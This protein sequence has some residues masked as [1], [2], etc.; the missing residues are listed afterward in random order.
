MSITDNLPL[1]YK[2]PDEL[3]AAYNFVSRADM[4]RGRIGVDNWHLLRYFFN[5]LAKAGSVSPKSYEPFTF[6]S[7]PIRVITL[8]WTKGKRTML[9]G[10]CTKIGQR[11]HVSRVTAKNDFIP[12][13]KV[14]LAK[15]RADNVVSWLELLPE[16]VEF[17]SKMNRF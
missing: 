9:D 17:I 7:P 13:L 8:F 12:F 15:N 16:E 14:L 5:S 2:D 1:R 4:F 3:A 6:I 10:V 11:C